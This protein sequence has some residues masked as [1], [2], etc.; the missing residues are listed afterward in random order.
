MSD[1]IDSVAIKSPLA[2]KAT[3]NAPMDASVTVVNK[4]N[5]QTW[6]TN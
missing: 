3:A 2:T 4:D 5:V 6:T 1:N